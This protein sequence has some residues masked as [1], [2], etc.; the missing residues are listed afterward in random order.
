M[1]CALMLS[2]PAAAQAWKGEGDQKL[3]IG[4]SGWGNGTGLT[5]T[6]DY[7]LSNMLSLGAGANIYFDGYRDD[8]DNNNFFIFGRL[9]V[10]L[11]EALGLPS[12]W[13]VYPGLDVGV[14]GNSFGLGAHIGARYF[15]NEK[16]GA[17]LEAGNNGSVGV[18][19]NL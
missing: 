7:G 13:D 15:F 3:Q 17:F 4:L 6:Y 12:Q 18:S 5:G 11:Q 8:N 1:A 14:L 16:I 19:I 10:H 9:N 2:A